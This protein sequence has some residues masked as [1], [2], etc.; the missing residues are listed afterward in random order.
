[1]TNHHGLPSPVA[2][3]R[4]GSVLLT[5]LLAVGII[6]VAVMASLTLVSSERRAVDD[7]QLQARALGI[8]Q[9]GMDAYLRHPDNPAFRPGRTVHLPPLDNDTAWVPVNASAGDTA[10]IIPRLF[11]TSLTA[12]RD[13]MYVISSL[14]RHAARS[15]RGTP[16]AQRAVAEIVTWT[17]ATLPV[18]A[19]WM[20]L[21]GLTKNGASGTLSGIDNS[22]VPCLPGGNLAGVMVP[23]SPGY[24]G[25]TSPL[26]GNP[27][28]DNTTLGA[29][30]QTAA[31]YVAGLGID[32]ADWSQGLNLPNVWRTSDHG[33]A[34]PSFTD[35]TYYPIVYVSGDVPML[36]SGRSLLVVSGNMTMNG[37]TTWD[38][39]VLIGGTVT[40][41]GND[42]IEGSVISGLNLITGSPAVA[43]GSIGN[44]TKTIV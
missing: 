15:I 40:A 20:S 26:S 31:A 9:Q 18:K 33:G 34:F 35:P 23:A 14:G 19:G 37:L 13:T 10:T 21:S 43:A 41:N 7:Q 28:L 12:T 6:T 44:G 4:R 16:T 5:A 11:H 27:P 29:T 36:P 2:R 22:P 42:N 38:G 17:G 32:W 39:M 30:P 1:M 8:A 25:S 3:G 24:S